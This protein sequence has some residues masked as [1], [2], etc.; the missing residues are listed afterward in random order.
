MKTLPPLRLK[1]SYW[2]DTERQVIEILRDLLFRPLVRIVRQADQDVKVKALLDTSHALALS[3]AATDDALLAAM[4]SGRVQ[5]MSGVFS[6]DFSARI[7]S[8][9]RRMGATFDARSRVFKIDQSLVPSW[10]K[11]EAAG[12]QI[13]AREVHDLLKR[14]LGETQKRIVHDINIRSVDAKK[15]TDAVEEG[16]KGTA[17]KLEVSPELNE[18][19]KETLAEEYSRNLKLDIQKFA[20]Q[21][22]FGLREAV[23]ANAREGYRFDKLIPTIKRRYGISVRKAKFLARNET[24]IFMSK[25]HEQRYGEAGITSYVWSTSHDARVRPAPGTHG[26]DNHR[27]LDG[28]TFD[29]SKPPTVDPATGRKANPGQDYNCRCVAIPILGDRAAAMTEY[30]EQLQ[31]AAA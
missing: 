30:R 22:I 5:Y 21:E 19:S 29:F 14:Q 17:K 26:T 3:N 10:L 16:F 8:A 27:V 15:T 31:E 20:D 13:R 6:G 25:Y 9:L 28:R 24:S 18:R 4:R 23:E 2:R 1:P 7:S 12:Y 11:A